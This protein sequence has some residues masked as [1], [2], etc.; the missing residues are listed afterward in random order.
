MAVEDAGAALAAL[1]DC[2]ATGVVNVASGQGASV[3]DVVAVVERALGTRTAVEWNGSLPSDIPVMLADAGRLARDAG[4]RA[5]VP[6][7]SA[8]RRLLSR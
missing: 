6:L 7:E 2:E 4:F 3:Q 1:V 5:Q 8:L